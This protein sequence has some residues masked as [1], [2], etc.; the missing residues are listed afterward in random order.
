[1]ARIRSIKPETF[2][3]AT[4]AR[5]PIEARF[6]FVGIW[7]EADDEGKLIDSAKLL[8]GSLFPHD[9]HV[10]AKCVERWLTALVG[11]DAIVRY[12][13]NG[14]KYIQ[15][16]EWKH[17]KISH[18]GPSRI[19]NPSGNIPESLAN[20]SGD[21][22]EFLRPDLG[23]R[24][25]GSRIIGSVPESERHI[26]VDLLLGFA[27]FWETYPKRNGKRL[28]RGDCEERWK[29]LGTDDRS[30]IVVGVR[31]YATAC[32]GGL[33]IAKDPMRWLRDK[34]WVDW[35]EPAEPCRGGQSVGTSGWT[36]NGMPI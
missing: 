33:T 14:A 21:S 2:T 20:N 8:A 18:P 36:M 5:V 29:K 32:D 9:E 26:D 10:T 24:I 30:A 31:H 22:P 6:L 17:Q 19:P 11:V 7:T 4:L 28:G 16:R 34:C 13:V 27:E 12:E 25:I 23:S 1:M 35:Q 15:V 3:S